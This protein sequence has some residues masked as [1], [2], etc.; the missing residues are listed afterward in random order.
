MS[1]DTLPAQLREAR[2]RRKLSQQQLASKLGISQEM[3]SM[4]EDGVKAIPSEL[5]PMVR[6]FVDSGRTPTTDE[7]HARKNTRPGR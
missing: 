4:V 6:R 7:L 1:D 2:K 5:V 3:L